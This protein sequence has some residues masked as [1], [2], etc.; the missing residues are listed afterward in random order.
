MDIAVRDGKT[1]L[2]ENQTWIGKTD[3]LRD[4]DSI[5]L[6][7]SAF[8]LA[9]T[10]AD[11][12]IPSGVALGRITATGLYGP[13]DDTAVDGTEVAAGFLVASIAYDRNSSADL[14]AALMWHGEVIEA[15]LPTDHGLDAAGKVDLAAKFRF[16]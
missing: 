1:F 10:F 3:A 12:F 2:N 6:D 16:V 14:G 9:V 15:N 7:R 11:G 4:A 5:T 13:Y 8:D